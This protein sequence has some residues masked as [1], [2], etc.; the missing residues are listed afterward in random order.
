MVDFSIDET[1]RQVV[2]TANKFAREIL[3]P[4]EIELD[5]MADPEAAF[6]SELFKNLLAD[7]YRLGFHKMALPEHMGGLGLDPVTLGMVWEE[8]ATGG[9]GFTA[10]LLPIAVV[11]RIVAIFAGSNKE[12]VERYVKGFCEDETGSQIGAWCSSEPEVGSDGSNYYDTNVRHYTNAKKKG[13]RYII[14]GTKSNFVSNGGLANVYLVFACVDPSQGIRGS[15]AFIV[16]RDTPGVS[17][18]TA[19]D[20][21]GLRALNQSP[22]F[23]DDV[24]VPE[25]NLVFPPGDNYPMFHNAIVTVGNIAVGYLAVG[26]MRAAYEEAKKYAKERVQ[27][28][29]PIIE[30]QLIASKLFKAHMAIE[31]A[32]AL[33]WKA[34]W[35][36]K[37]TFPGD[38]KTSLAGKIY[39]TTEA[40]KH[41]SEM[42]QALGAYGISREYQVEKC[43]RDTK[44]LQMMDG[45]NEILML[46]AA[47]ELF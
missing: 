14:N 47:R 42:V 38:L 46:K 24:E 8:L 11:A 17:V 43:M 30:H 15:G 7:S 13:D 36:S 27:W 22:V 18:G 29:K 12:L 2:G 45:A 25:T 10:G 9:A 41:T 32:R 6:K 34:S 37:T 20:K 28:G 5:L 4:A 19:L 35:L 16:P 31:S 1:Q 3:K 21:I 26:L 23:F 44:P 39:A 33:L 40:V